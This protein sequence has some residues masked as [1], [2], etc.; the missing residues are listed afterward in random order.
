[1]GEPVLTAQDRSADYRALRVVYLPSFGRPVA[2]R[3]EGEGAAMQRRAIG[4]EHGGAGARKFIDRRDTVSVAEFAKVLNL[5]ETA[6]LFTLPPTDDTRGF[7][8]SWLV[9]EAVIH[10]RRHVVTRWSPDI[11]SKP[12]RLEALVAACTR[13]LEQAGLRQLPC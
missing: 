11:D 3:Y 13:T 5:Y 4:L 6:G 10:G 8:G 2:I 1:M 12:R 9:V 7:D